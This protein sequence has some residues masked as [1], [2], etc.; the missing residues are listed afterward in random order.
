MMRPNLV[1]EE[2]KKMLG[3]S[4]WLDNL[5]QPAPG[6]PIGPFYYP[7]PLSSINPLQKKIERELGLNVGQVSNLSC[8][9]G[10]KT[11]L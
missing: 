4:I 7:P 1:I 8:E 5:D 10:R 2:K 9:I 3:G 6:V 11:N